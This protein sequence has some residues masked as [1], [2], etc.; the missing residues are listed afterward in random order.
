MVSADPTVYV[1]MFLSEKFGYKIKNDSDWSLG[2]EPN[3]N[4]PYN[5]CDQVVYGYDIKFHGNYTLKNCKNT[6]LKQCNC[7]GF[8]YKFDKVRGFYNCFIKSL[9]FNGYLSSHLVKQ[10]VNNILIT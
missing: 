10:L 6:C 5:D 7:Y 4:P 8:Q 9:L 2:C 3:F 1:L